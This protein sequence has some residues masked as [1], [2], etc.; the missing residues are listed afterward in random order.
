L[1]SGFLAGFDPKANH[2]DVDQSSLIKVI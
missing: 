1:S 2:F